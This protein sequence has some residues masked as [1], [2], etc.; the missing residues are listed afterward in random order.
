MEGDRQL[1]ERPPSVTKN[2]FRYSSMVEDDRMA[3]ATPDTPTQPAKEWKKEDFT[4]LKQLGAGR[5]AT[6]YSAVEKKSNLKVAIKEIPKK[7][8]SNHD[9]QHQV[10]REVEIH[11]RLNHPNIIKLFGYFQDN[12]NIYLV[13]EFA[14]GGTLYDLFTV[15]KR[16]WTEEEAKPLTYQMLHAVAYLQM[17]QII[18]RDI[19]LENVLLD[20]Q[21]N[22][23]LSDFGWAVHTT[24]GRRKSFCGTLIYLSPEQSRKEE[25]NCSIDIWSLGILTYEM[26]NGSPPFCGSK[27]DE[28]FKQIQEKTLDDL[29]IENKFESSEL[30]NLLRA[31]GP[32]THSDAG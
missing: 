27:P 19:K 16:P 22:P 6:V 15:R 21:G 18:H 29:G 11:S 30:K 31:V 1:S 20:A 3:P 4:V 10:R 23:K 28:V 26:I 13:M 12:K 14:E 24:G 2:F 7:L 8:I 9:F 25:Y 5:F 17:R 32:L